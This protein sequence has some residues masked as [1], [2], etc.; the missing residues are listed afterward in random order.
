MESRADLIG[1]YLLA[2][3]IFCAFT[4]RVLLFITRSLNNSNF[5]LKLP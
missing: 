4:V 2:F 5:S 3:F 1:D